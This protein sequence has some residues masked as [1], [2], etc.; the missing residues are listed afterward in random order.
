MSDDTL[1]AKYKYNHTLDTSYTIDVVCERR[2]IAPDSPIPS[3]NLRRQDEAAKVLVQLSEGVPVEQ[4]W[5]IALDVKHSATAVALIS[6]GTL[7]A[8]IVHPRDI[9]RFAI[10]A[11]AAAVIVGHNHPSGDP[12][13][14][15]EDLKLSSRLRDAGKTIG[16]PLLDSLV[17]T[18]SGA[19]TSC[20]SDQNS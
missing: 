11:N 18:E 13:P 16:I 5:A 10:L 3:S 14:S 20:F 15:S 12:A 2:E 9:F 1:T 6:R 4:F 17:V 8:T 19:W 7:A